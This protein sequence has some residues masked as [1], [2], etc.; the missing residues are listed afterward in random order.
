MLQVTTEIVNELDKLSKLM[1]IKKIIV[2]P[3]ELKQLIKAFHENS[4]H[5][6]AKI[7]PENVEY[8][9]RIF[10]CGIEIGTEQYL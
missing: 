9:D 1:T 8:L 6:I 7:T 2:S 5:I 10:V 3:E 4:D